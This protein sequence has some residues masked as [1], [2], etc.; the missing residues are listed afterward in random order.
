MLLA[1]K[2][3]QIPVTWTLFSCS[4][5][6][7]KGKHILNNKSTKTYQVAENLLL[8]LAIISVNNEYPVYF[9][10]FGFSV[11]AARKYIAAP[12]KIL[13]NEVDVITD[14]HQLFYLVHISA[15]QRHQK[16]DIRNS[17][18]VL[19]YCCFSLK[20]HSRLC[21]EISDRSRNKFCFRPIKLFSVLY[22]TTQ[23]TD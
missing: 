18:Q 5:H 19:W 8:L 13:T 2:G 10:Q 21:I 23:L 17:A 6:A 1:T 16:Q 20:T 11:L 9:Y 12:Y 4:V 15:I 22:Y 7:G 3:Y 14:R